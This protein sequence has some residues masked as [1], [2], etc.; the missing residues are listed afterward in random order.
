MGGAAE[1]LTD[2][3]TRQPAARRTWGLLRKKRAEGA[4]L[5]ARSKVEALLKIVEGSF[6]YCSLRPFD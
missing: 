2:K 3:R 1:E 6:D 5:L 4:K